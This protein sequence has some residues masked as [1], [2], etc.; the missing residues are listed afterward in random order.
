MTNSAA[1]VTIT[2]RARGVLAMEE[3]LA[4]VCRQIEAE[5]ARHNAAMDVLLTKQQAL[6]TAIFRLVAN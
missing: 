6:E 2:T 5:K 1:I 3:E 4:V